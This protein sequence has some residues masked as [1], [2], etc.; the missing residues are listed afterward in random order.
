L[1]HSAI[2]GRAGNPLRR[3]RV[4]ALRIVAALLGLVGL[5][6]AASAE[7]L[8]REEFTQNFVLAFKAARPGT[9]IRVRGPLLLEIVDEKGTGVT[10]YLENAFVDYRLDPGDL[11]SIIRT[12]VADYP[13]GLPAAGRPVDRSRIVPVVKSRRWIADYA[14]LMKEQGH[15]DASVAVHDK[16]NDELVVV[17]AEDRDKTYRF[18][19]PADVTRLG[20]DGDRDE[21]ALLARE[22]L[23]RLAP[24]PELY[25]G[26]YAH[27]IRIDG[28][29]EASLILYPEWWEDHPVKVDGDYVIAVPARDI[30]MITGSNNEA[31]LAQ[32]RALARQVVE[33]ESHTIV[34]TLFVFRDGRFTRFE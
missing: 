24:P 6:H 12:H 16:L 29:Y 1:D 28:N 30:L 33:R 26:P 14:A 31:G 20:L 34:E 5:L 11:Q 25:S 4:V 21:L 9:E 22:N 23:A 27:G 18:L 15:G 8:S 32:L 10:A 13:S 17:Y 2:A 7:P 3:S 19:V